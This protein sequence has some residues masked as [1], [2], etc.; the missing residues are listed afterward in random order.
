MS[1]LPN[2]EQSDSADVRYWQSR[3]L[4]AEAKAE[5]L[6][7]AADDLERCCPNGVADRKSLAALKLETL[8]TLTTMST[9]QSWRTVARWELQRR[10][11][12]L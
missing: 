4:A 7:A 3:A 12:T 1:D 5:Q 11:V 9:D 8:R 10:R 6:E 2:D